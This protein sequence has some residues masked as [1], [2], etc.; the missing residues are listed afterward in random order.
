MRKRKFEELFFRVLMILATIIVSGSFFLIVGTIFFKGLPY[1]NWDMITKTPGGGFYIGKE[2]GILNAII[3]SFY[4]AG[5]ATVLG[6]IISIPVAI[7]INLYMDGKRLLSNTI[8]MAFDVLFG[9]PSIVYGAFG[10]LIMVYFGIRAS[11]LGGIIAVTL[12]VIPI[13]VRTLDEVIRTVPFELRDATLSLGATRLETAKVVLRQIRPG[14]FTAILLSFGRAIG[15]VA[16]V[17]FTAG[18]SDNIPTSLHEPAATLP[19]AIFFQLGSPVEEV[20]G[21]GYAS[22]LILTIIVLIITV[23]ADILIKKFSKHKI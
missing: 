12:L 7:F 19:L 4:V 18:F 15:D 17:L 23:L 13:L 8:R 16:S 22:A 11:L 21:R 6:L 1:M 5:G 14:I 10:F 2:G 20:Q 9:I 3:G